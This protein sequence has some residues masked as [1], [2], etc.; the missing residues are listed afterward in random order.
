VGA[1]IR[2]AVL[3]ASADPPFTIGQP[4]VNALPDANVFGGQV[5]IIIELRNP[6]VPTPA[7]V[8]LVG[9]GLGLMFSRRC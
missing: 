4:G 3:D 1:L 7:T 5:D 8:G 2:G 6:I 9:A